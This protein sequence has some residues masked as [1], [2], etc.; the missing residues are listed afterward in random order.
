MAERRP[1]GSGMENL[2]ALG[3]A[4]QYGAAALEAGWNPLQRLSISRGEL[5]RSMDLVQIAAKGLSHQAHIRCIWRNQSRAVRPTRAAHVFSKQIPT[6]QALFGDRTLKV[7]AVNDPNS[8]ASQRF[9]I[10]PTQGFI[11]GGTAASQ[12]VDSS[13]RSEMK[14]SNTIFKIRDYRSSFSMIPLS[15]FAWQTGLLF[16]PHDIDS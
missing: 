13:D 2:D 8:S 3:A 5:T 1:N 9:L 7:L 16:A 14:K 6:E 4:C 10:L 11:A 12:R 15:C